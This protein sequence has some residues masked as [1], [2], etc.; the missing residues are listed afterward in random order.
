[1]RRLSGALLAL[2]LAGCASDGRE[3][4]VTTYVP[5][6]PPSAADEV[7][8]YM[9]SLRSMNDAAL[10]AEAR[11]QRNAARGERD[12]D[13]ARVKAAL[14]LSL[15]SASEESEI[16]SLVDPVARREKGDAGLKAMA[17]FLHGLAL[18]RRRLKE[19]AAA[20]SARLREE[21]RSQ[22]QLRSAAN[23]A[24]ERAAQLQQ[25]LDALSALEKSLSD[26][27][28]PTR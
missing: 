20:A 14:A 12:G 19:S 3:A 7:A 13:L 6:S 24:Q 11:R 27:T 25:K 17:S 26:R 16:I 4:P 9:G 10:A 8:A 18:D 2:A 5:R 28:E 1:V 23:A 22:E 15:A 21:R